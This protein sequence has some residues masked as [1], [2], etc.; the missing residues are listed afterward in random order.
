MNMWTRKGISR[1]NANF[2]ALEQLVVHSFQSR[3]CA[4]LWNKLGDPRLGSTRDDID[5]ILRN[6]DSVRLHSLIGEVVNCYELECR[7]T[8]TNLETILHS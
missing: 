7:Y 2:H 3:I 6:Y 8:T 4:F 1:T 5:R